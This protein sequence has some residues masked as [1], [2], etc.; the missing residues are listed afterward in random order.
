LLVADLDPDRR[1]GQPQGAKARR[2][3]TLQLV[4]DDADI[5][6]RVLPRIGAQPHG[7]VHERHGS[8]LPVQ[9]LTAMSGRQGNRER[10]HRIHQMQQFASPNRGAVVRAELQ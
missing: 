10:F 8:I 9:H 2:T 1:R 7:Q 4:A 3:C 5:F 6:S